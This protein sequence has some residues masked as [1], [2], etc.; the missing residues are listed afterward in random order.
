MFKKSVL[1]QRNV[2]L[3]WKSEQSS[4]HVFTQCCIESPGHKHAPMSS[5]DVLTPEVL[6]VSDSQVR[7]ELCNWKL[8]VRSRK[9]TTENAVLE[10]E[11]A[12]KRVELALSKYVPI[13]SQLMFGGSFFAPLLLI[14]NIID[15]IFMGAC[16]LVPESFNFSNIASFPISYNIPDVWGLQKISLFTY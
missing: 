2:G 10:T 11:K 16:H 6:A 5:V 9:P 8:E 14:N 4:L 15:P 13:L 1:Y 12:T 3:D 7:P